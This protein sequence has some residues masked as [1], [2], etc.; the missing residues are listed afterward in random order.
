MSLIQRFLSFRAVVLPLGGI[1]DYEGKLERLEEVDRE[2]EDPAVWEDQSRAQGLGKE[3]A[4]LESIITTLDRIGSFLT[5]ADQLS[6]LAREEADDEALQ[7]IS[8]DVIKTQ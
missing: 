7:D 2:L 8:D 1:F 6:R 4:S 5:D 3:R